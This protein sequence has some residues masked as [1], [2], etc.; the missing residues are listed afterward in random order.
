MIGIILCSTCV[1]Y[2]V[3]KCY[4]HCLPCACGGISLCGV[5]ECILIGMHSLCIF[6]RS[7]FPLTIVAV[8]NDTQVSD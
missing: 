6:D 1:Q 3:G 5:K 8:L 2:D 4:L 7:S